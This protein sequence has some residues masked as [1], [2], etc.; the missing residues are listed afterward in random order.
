MKVRNKQAVYSGITLI[1]I[2]VLFN[3]L[4]IEAALLGGDSIRNV[5]GNLLIGI[6]QSAA[7]ISGVFL[8][9]KQPSIKHPTKGELILL[10]SSILATLVA[11]EL[12]ARFWLNNLAT[13]QQ[14]ANY[15]S[16]TDVAPEEFQ[17][18]PHP[19]LNYY[20]TP[21]YK[22]G[23]TSHNS[24]GY[25]NNEFPLEKPD[26]VYRIAVLG[27]SSTYTIKVK[28]NEKTFPSQLERLLRDEYAYPNVEVIN[29]GVGGYNSWESLIN[30]QFRVLDV[31]S[32]LVIV[33]HGVNDVYASSPSEK[34][35][36]RV[37]GGMMGPVQ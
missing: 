36:W 14:Y 20:P 6:F 18:S 27:G 31:D 33:Y 23:L 17:W 13:P 8:L 12:G 10:V 21:N 29:A 1:A 7:I 35:G 22:N 26:G 28:D 11:G 16:F 4:L 15:A 3:K 37:L 32:D 2:G 34:H 24:L 9:L 30:L 25:R 19:Y 5:Q